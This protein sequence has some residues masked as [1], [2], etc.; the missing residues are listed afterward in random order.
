MARMRASAGRLVQHAR[1]RLSRMSRSLADAACVREPWSY[2]WRE[3][4]PRQSVGRY[5]LRRG[6]VR[7]V[8]RHHTD[9]TGVFAEIFRAD[10]YALPARVVSEL[11]SRGREATFAD[12]GANVGLFSAWV[13]AH[14]PAA[15]LIAFEPDPTTLVQLREVMALNGAPGQWTL[16]PE[17]VSNADGVVAFAASGSSTSHV[18]E[19]DS[20]D[21]NAEVRVCDAF[22]HLDA[23]DVLKMDIEGGEWRILLDPRWK[24]VSVEVVL[25]EYHPEGCPTSDARKLARELLRSAGYVVEDIAHNA[26][27]HGML[28]AMRA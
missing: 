28:R 19:P 10:F 1:W 17:C 18:T 23:V 12:F 3:L 27:G 16:I 6:S 7:V 9:D 26:A 8:L 4:R 5:K 2:V 11:R 20:A 24:N 25:M 13:L 15:R 21:A 14:F 22:R